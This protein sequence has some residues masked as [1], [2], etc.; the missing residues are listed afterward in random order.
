[1]QTMKSLFVY[2]NVVFMKVIVLPI[3]NESIIY[4]VILYCLQILET[5]YIY[6]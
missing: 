4:L 1:M 3:P 5:L 6:V 2:I